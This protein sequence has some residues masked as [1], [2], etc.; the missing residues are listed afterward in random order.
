M[1]DEQD[2]NILLFAVI[3]IFTEIHLDVFDT[4]QC[5]EL[6]SKPIKDVTQ[7]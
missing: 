5:F 4:K 2:L 3:L 7:N 6:I 1:V